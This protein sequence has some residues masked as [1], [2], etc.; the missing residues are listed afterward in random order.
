MI[1][2]LIAI[3]IFL[4]IYA[5]A[6]WW[7]IYQLNTNPPTIE[8]DGDLATLGMM[9]IFLHLYGIARGLLAAACYGNSIFIS[10][11]LKKLHGK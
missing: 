8:N 11:F 4:I 9:P 3:S 6:Y 10:Y 2:T 5:L 1:R 7:G